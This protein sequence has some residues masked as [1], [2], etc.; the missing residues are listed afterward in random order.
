MSYIESNED[1]NESPNNYDQLDIL[2]DEKL[3]NILDDFSNDSNSNSNSNSKVQADKFNQI[4][5]ECNS[6]NIIFISGRG[7][8]S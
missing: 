8:L 7:C 1:L 3:W 6:S 5:M 4:C 2:S